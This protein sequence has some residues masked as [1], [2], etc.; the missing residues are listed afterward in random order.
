MA[1]ILAVD[2]SSDETYAALSRSSG[3][4]IERNAAHSSRNEELA[5]LVKSLLDEAG[6][7]PADLT[8]LAVGAGPGSFTGLRIGFSFM[9]G[10]ALA[11]AKPLSAICSFAAFAAE[12]RDSARLLLTVA[13][14]R[15][16]ELFFAA[17]TPAAGRLLEEVVEPCIVPRAVLRERCAELCDRFGVPLQEVILTGAAP[18]GDEL[19]P[20]IEC[21]KPRHVARGLALLAGEAHPQELSFSI[22]RLAEDSP[23]YLRAVNAKTIAEREAERVLTESRKDGYN[24]V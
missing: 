24:R 10:F 5:L 15:R 18:R 19:V 4:V 22:H 16:E 2:T 11:S 12:F 21:R 1:A 9:K 20:G 6:L 7:T 23:R 13:D 8:A 17:Y 3:E 14:A